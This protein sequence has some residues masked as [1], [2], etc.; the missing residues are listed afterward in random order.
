MCARVRA[1]ANPKGP[2]S[3]LVQLRTA[4][5]TG[6]A[7]DTRPRAVIAALQHFPYC[8]LL[9]FVSDTVGLGVGAPLAR[10]F[11]SYKREEQSYAFVVCQWLLD[12]QGWPAEDI[13]VDV[14]HLH[15]GVE[16]EKKAAHRSRSRRGDA[17]Y[18]FRPVARHPL[19]LLPGAPARERTNTG[20]SHQG[21]HPI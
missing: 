1:R 17:V 14:G 10:L 11:I 18:C 12:E 19:I 13:F 6:Y 5:W 3:S 9:W 7:R 21:R 2:P 16:W 4:V 20:R 15:A 8:A